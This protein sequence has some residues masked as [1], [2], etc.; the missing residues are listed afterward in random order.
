[1]RTDPLPGVR[2]RHPDQFFLG[3][4]WV[5]PSSSSVFNVVNP[6]T[7]ETFL[8]VA[9]AQE[10]DIEAAIT[11]A[12][13]A[14]DAGPWPRLSHAERAVYMRAMAAKIRERSGELALI[15]TSQMGMLYADT[16][17]FVAGL[18]GVYEYYADFAENFDFVER[19]D[20]TTGGNVGLLVREPVGVVGAIVPWNGPLPLTLYKTA[21]AL[22]AGCTV[23]LKASP[24]AP[25]EAYV[26]AEIA[27]EVGLPPGVLNLV[28]ADREVS[29]LMVRDPRVD[30]VSFTGSTAAGRRIA[31]L[32]G[33]RIGRYTLELGGK[34]AAV[35]LDDYDIATVAE[36]VAGQ[37]VRMTGQA[38]SSLTRV[39]VS[40]SR[41]DEFVEALVDLF[42]RVTVGDPFDATV[43][44]GPLATER[45]LDKV[46]G[47][48][49][50]GTAN[51]A[52]LAGGGRRPAALDVGYFVEPTVFARVDNSSPIAQEEIF[53]P[54][55]SVIA[56]DSDRHAIALA[57]DSPY[58]LNASVYT[59]DSD[60]ALKVARQLRCGTVAH[61][62]F[63]TDFGIAFG[64]FKQSGIGREGGREGILPYL[65]TKTITLDSE[66]GAMS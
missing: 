17:P 1:M 29:E 39:I 21:P 7:E 23:I 35:V 16:L 34:S 42:S 50:M 20:P 27:E 64:G 26:F 33:K 25:G 36:S 22:I 38:C 12:R 65:E 18:G 15:W 59:C 24:E 51:G 30:K 61:N 11:A 9:A 6:A 28:T 8:R 46:L 2:L 45:Q 37:A 10:A 13:S 66:P 60:R 62:A 63:R 58:G 32:M 53:G 4:E 40:R 44:M 54:V 43:G 52:V 31:S 56:A 41:H 48:I 57:N 47:Y 3:G 5:R 14:F 19:H 55:I 49:D